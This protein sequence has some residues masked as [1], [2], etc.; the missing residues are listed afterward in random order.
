MTMESNAGQPPRRS[1]TRDDRLKAIEA[2]QRDALA[3]VDKNPSAAI[4]GLHVADLS[5]SEQLLADR[6]HSALLGEPPADPP[7]GMGRLHDSNVRG[8]KE[9]IK[10][11]D[12]EARLEKAADSEPDRRLRRV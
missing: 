8:I 2:K 3:K 12:L 11:I 1:L 7:D 10:L 6:I 4:V 9:V 5:F